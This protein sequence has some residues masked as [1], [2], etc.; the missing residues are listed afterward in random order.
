M[1]AA[2]AGSGGAI[3]SRS[4]QSLAPEDLSTPAPI[5][6]LSYMPA[7]Y[8]CVLVQLYMCPRTTMYASSYYY[9]CVLRL[10]Y[11]CPDNAICVLILLLYTCPHTTTCCPN[12]GTLSS[13]APPRASHQRS[14]PLP[15]LYHHSHICLL[16][17]VCTH[18]TIYVSSYSY[19]CVL[20]LLYMCPHSICIYVSSYSTT[21]VSSFDICVLVLHVSS[22]Y[23][24]CPH[25]TTYVPSYYKICPHTNMCVLI[26]L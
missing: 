2:E 25:T 19:I 15:L 17:Y 9:I 13:P 18:T 26:L 20:I 1:T 5:P 24:M 23:Y 14:Y 8:M 7:L 11:M 6:P 21:Y 4:S 10:L 22:Y 3:Y 12:T 16:L